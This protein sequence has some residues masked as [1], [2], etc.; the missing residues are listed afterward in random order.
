MVFL[1]TEV[2]L[3]LEV[4]DS[5]GGEIEGKGGLVR[6]V[7]KVP[8]VDSVCLSDEDH[9]SSGWGEGSTSVVTAECIGRAEN[10]IV[11]VYGSFP[12]AEVEVMYSEQQ[13]LIEWR[14][15]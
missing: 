8:N 10:G 14:S 6:L 13:I 9:T 7:N 15:L 1:V 2:Q 3:E 5:W 11:K 12:D 4:C